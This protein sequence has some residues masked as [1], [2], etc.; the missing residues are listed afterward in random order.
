MRFMNGMPVHGLLARLDV[1]VRVHCLMLKS[2][3]WLYVKLGSP[4]KSHDDTKRI[5][6][7][8]CAYSWDLAAFNL[9]ALRFCSQRKC[10]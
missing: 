5:A 4:I 8:G 9:C 1:D 2:K 10:R 6:W 3:Y 7:Y